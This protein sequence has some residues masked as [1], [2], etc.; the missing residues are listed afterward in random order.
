MAYSGQPLDSAEQ[1]F[2][3]NVNYQFNES[4]N[5]TI[6]Y[7]SSFPAFLT[8]PLSMSE[9]IFNSVSVTRQINENLLMSMIE[10]EVRF[11]KVLSENIPFLPNLSYSVSDFVLLS[12]S[13]A[14]SSVLNYNRIAVKNSETLMFSVQLNEVSGSREKAMVRAEPVVSTIEIVEMTIPKMIF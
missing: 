1:S 2:N 13:L 9:N 8:S 11:P 10:S 14:I 7:S 6:I 3:L 5:P 12:R 4:V